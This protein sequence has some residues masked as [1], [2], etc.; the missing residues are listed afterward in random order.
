MLKL[1]T[2]KFNQLMANKN[3]E[4]FDNLYADI[5]ILKDDK[6]LNDITYLASCL[7]SIAFKII[8]YI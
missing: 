4:G 2:H 5:G 6:I 7:S 8:S 1:L 3:R